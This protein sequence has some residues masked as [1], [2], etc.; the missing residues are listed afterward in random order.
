MG[1]DNRAFQEEIVD[2]GKLFISYREQPSEKQEVL[3]H[4]SKRINNTNHI[5]I[6][7]YHKETVDMGNPDIHSYSDQPMEKHSY[8]SS[9]LSELTDDTPAMSICQN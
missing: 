4:S 9:E 7:A 1:I 3:D 5:A 8:T 2:I 6:E